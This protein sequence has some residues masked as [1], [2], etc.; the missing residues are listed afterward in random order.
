MRLS[1]DW[2]SSSGDYAIFLLYV[3]SVFFCVVRQTTTPSTWPS[4]WTHRTVVSPMTSQRDELNLYF[5]PLPSFFYLFLCIIMFFAHKPIHH[6]H[7]KIIKLNRI[8]SPLFGVL[9]LCMCM[10]HTVWKLED[11]RH[12]LVVIEILDNCSSFKILFHLICRE[13][14]EKRKRVGA[15]LLVLCNLCRILTFLSF[16]LV[17]DGMA[18][19]CSCNRSSIIAHSSLLLC[20]HKASCREWKES[21]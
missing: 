17:V 13:W 7:A 21:R 9:L 15:I 19:F 11:A 18:R 14:R 20:E 2:L 12:E 3:S 4:S 10:A 6:S 1:S 16:G 5:S 8:F